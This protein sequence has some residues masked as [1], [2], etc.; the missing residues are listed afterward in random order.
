MNDNTIDP[1][2]FT[3]DDMVFDAFVCG[4]VTGEPVILLYGFPEFAN[5]WHEIM[6][7]LGSAGFRAIAFNQRGYSPGARPTRRRQYATD[8]LVANVLAIAAAAGYDRFHLA[9]H[10][11]G[12]IVAWKLVAKRPE[13]LRSLV[14]LSTPH[15]DALIDALRLDA[16]QRR[17]SRYIKVFRLPLHFAE[18][19]LLRND[20]RA[21]KATFKD[22]LPKQRLQDY[23][24]RFSEP[25]VL[26]AALNW[27]RELDLKTK[28][29]QISVPTLFI[30]GSEDQALGSA[31]AYATQNYVSARYRF[32]P[33]EA[34]SHW[35]LEEYPQRTSA[36]LIDHLRKPRLRTR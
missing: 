30:W 4:P 8:L 15:V 19:L 25:G 22:K 14:V 5:S 29:G 10:D 36:L 24:R 33:I 20:A 9:G 27:Y 26:T 32:E 13:R 28:I 7:E 21:L 18:W 3:T 2:T 1:V 16:D 6:S 12:G 17:K 34:A 11:W 23:L 35:L 31:A